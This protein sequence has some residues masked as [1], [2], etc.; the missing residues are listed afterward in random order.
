MGKEIIF[1]KLFAAGN[2][3]TVFLARES[4][5]ENTTVYLLYRLLF[6]IYAKSNM[7]D[8]MAVKMATKPILF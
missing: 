2:A 4:I 6:M 1:L 5:G 7:A 3:F 8:K